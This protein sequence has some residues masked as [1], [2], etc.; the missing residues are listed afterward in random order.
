MGGE[1]R[2]ELGKSCRAEWATGARQALQGVGD[3]GLKL[4]PLFRSPLPPTRH[5]S[6]HPSPAHLWGG[7]P[8]RM[9][10]AARAGS[11][12]ADRNES[13]RA[14]TPP[15]APPAAP[16]R[17]RPAQQPGPLDPA[18]PRAAVA[19]QQPGEGPLRPGRHRSDP[20][21]SGSLALPRGH[22]RPRLSEPNATMS[23]DSPMSRREAQPGA[24]SLRS[25]PGRLIEAALAPGVWHRMHHGAA[26]CTHAERV[27]FAA[28]SPPTQCACACPPCPPP[29]PPLR[30]QRRGN[31]APSDPAGRS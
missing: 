30:R 24:G 29:R 20:E 9:C 12:P 23:Q 22:W 31:P 2:K 5:P 10:P 18:P 17:P 27:A 13:V 14:Q 6:S 7:W 8:G 21:G 19:Q 25:S 28:Q 1:G 11:R 4:P 15:A 3:T 26:P 16:V